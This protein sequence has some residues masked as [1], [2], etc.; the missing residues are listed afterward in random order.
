MPDEVR[1]RS[2][3]VEPLVNGF[4]T[5]ALN[6]AIDPETLALTV[7]DRQGRR[8][9]A[10]AAKPISFD[11]NAFTLRKAMPVGR[12][13][14]RARRQ[15]RPVQPPRRELRQLEHRRLGLRSRHRPDLQVDPLLRSRAA[16]PAAPTAC[17]STTAGAA[18]S[19][20]AIATR[21]CSPFRADGGPI[22]YYLIAGPTV[23]DV[24][25]R[26]T[27][28]TG[29]APL[30]PRWALG[31]QQSRYSYMTRRGGAGDRGA[32]SLRPHPDGRPLA[33]HRLSRT[34][35]GRSRSTRRPS[36]T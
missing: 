2:V 16:A 23:A 12:A 19:T 21:T 4:E 15:D 24:V 10:D 6:V 36:R 17:S 13:I 5:G 26:Y 27:D 34:A 30:P 25:R 7:S 29:K 35:T 33:R 9:H 32:P 14:L 11:G 20:S 22:D 8:I 18:R 28:L 31:F 3:R 1:A